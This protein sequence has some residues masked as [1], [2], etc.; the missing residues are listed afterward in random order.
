MNVITS[1][2]YK[3]FLRYNKIDVSQP[4][5]YLLTVRKS[6]RL[7]HYWGITKYPPTVP[8]ITRVIR[9]LEYIDDLMDSAYF[10]LKVST[11]D[12]FPTFPGGYLIFGENLWHL[13]CPIFRYFYENE[14]GT[15]TTTRW[16]V[17]SFPI[18]KFKNRETILTRRI[19]IVEEMTDNFRKPANISEAIKLKYIDWAEPIGVVRDF[20]EVS[21]RVKI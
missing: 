6:D 19:S 5:S 4:S 13:S 3:D 20:I 21:G 17:N 1:T 16:D 14:N 12:K 15:I 2:E 11:V 7:N 8:I 9:F 10:M 18:L